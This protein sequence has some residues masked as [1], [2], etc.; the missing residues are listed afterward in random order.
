MV[1]YKHSIVNDERLALPE[2]IVA[3]G[4]R[5]TFKTEVN[6]FLGDLRQR[7]PLEWRGTAALSRK[8]LLCRGRSC[9]VEEE[10]ALSRKKHTEK[11]MEKRH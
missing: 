4:E 11:K 7:P 5:D 3:V 1:V 2:E 10:A 8:K 6:A 9:S